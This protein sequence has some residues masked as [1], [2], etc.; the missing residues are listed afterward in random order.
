MN[1]FIQLTKKD[2]PLRQLSNS[3]IDEETVK[4]VLINIDNIMLVEIT[5]K[6]SGDFRFET[7]ISLKNPCTT[8]SVEEDF[9]TINQMIQNTQNPSLCTYK[10]NER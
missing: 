2:I 5:R 10:E 7:R 1:Q 8:F 9:D 3:S 4:K 6:L